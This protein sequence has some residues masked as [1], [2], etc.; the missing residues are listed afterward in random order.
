MKNS[1]SNKIMYGF[2]GVW[3]IIQLFPLYWLITFSLKDNN[4]IFGGN[5][6]GFPKILRWENYKFAFS[7]GKIGTYFFNSV[8]V[9]VISLILITIISLMA[10]YAL[11][12][13]KWRLRKIIYALLMLGLMIPIHAS[14]LPVMI[15]LKKLH[16]LSTY[17]ALITPYTAFAIPF[18]IMIFSGFMKDIPQ[19]MEEAACIDG[20]NIYKMFF[21]IIVPLMKPAIA[22]SAIFNFLNIWNELMFATLFINDAKLK[23]LTAGIQSM[24]GQYVTEWGPIGAGLVIATFPT[25]I[26][27][28]LLSKQVQESLI[29]GA[30]KG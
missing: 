18:T 23:T 21:S 10:S 26:I 7:I 12:R 2:L 24:A 11:I 25:V 28:L 15:I 13:M 8:L 16:L 29:A 5:I 1:I 22:T 27:Y 9:T 14:I 3:T 17:W 6:I 19:E 30:V 20:C 4:E